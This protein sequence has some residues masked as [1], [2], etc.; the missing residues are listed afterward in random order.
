MD[1][2]RGLYPASYVEESVAPH[3]AEV[4]LP[5]HFVRATPN[6]GTSGM[7]RSQR[8]QK[9][10]KRKGKFSKALQ[11]ASIATVSDSLFGAQRVIFDQVFYL[12]FQT[13]KL[14][15]PLCKFLLSSYVQA[16]DVLRKSRR[17]KWFSFQAIN[18]LFNNFIGP[19]G[20]N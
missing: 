9:K 17:L 19:D 16:G 13:P 20:A 7:Q 11:P 12:Q 4:P 2:K 1:G 18:I 5:L 8:S 10:G 14:E 3:E 6:P 15:K